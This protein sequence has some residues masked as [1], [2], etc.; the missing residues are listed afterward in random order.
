ML[1]PSPSSVN[2]LPDLWQS[3]KVVVLVKVESL[4][5]DTIKALILK[6]WILSLLSAHTR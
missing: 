4:I 3:S 2:F 5:Q 1:T 6:P